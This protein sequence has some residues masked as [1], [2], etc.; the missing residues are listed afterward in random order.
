MEAKA[1]MRRSRPIPSLR[2]FAQLTDE[3]KRRAYVVGY[4]ALIGEGFPCT[5]SE[6]KKRNRLLAGYQRDAGWSS[7]QVKDLRKLAETEPAVLVVK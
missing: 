4:K 2:E 5:E 3:R 6:Q 1:D 7:E